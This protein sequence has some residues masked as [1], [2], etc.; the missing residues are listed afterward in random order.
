MVGHQ[1]AVLCC[2]WPPVGL[3]E[4]GW[5]WVHCALFS[6]MVASTDAVAGGCIQVPA[7]GACVRL[8]SETW[9][10]SNIPDNNR[11]VPAW[12]ACGDPDPHT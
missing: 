11:Q 6:A 10:G 7:W 2:S 3:A 9:Q 5:T 1:T 4:D 12:G 8:C